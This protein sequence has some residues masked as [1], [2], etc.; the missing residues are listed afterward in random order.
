MTNRVFLSAERKFYGVMP[1]RDGTWG[2]E[3]LPSLQ[4]GGLAFMGNLVQSVTHM[5]P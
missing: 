1:R 4:Q 2:Q 3:V 5:A